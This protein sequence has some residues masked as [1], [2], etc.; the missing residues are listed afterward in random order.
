MAEPDKRKQSLYFPKQML[1]EV[2]READRQDRSKSWIVRQAWEYAKK[3]IQ[4][5]PGVNDIPD[6]EPSDERGK[7]D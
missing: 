4:A 5:M 2:K 1:E 7:V 3:H 6:D